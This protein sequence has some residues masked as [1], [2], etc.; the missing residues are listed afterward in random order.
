M[1][2][3]GVEVAISARNAHRGTYRDPWGALRVCLP[4]ETVRFHLFSLKVPLL[5]DSTS[6][7]LSI[8][9]NNWLV[10]GCLLFGMVGDGLA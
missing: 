10:Y 9:G 7:R 3:G 6:G 2:P 1:P 4:E 8:A 5:V